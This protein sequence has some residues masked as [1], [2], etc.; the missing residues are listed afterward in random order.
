LLSFEEIAWLNGYHA[1]VREKIGKQID[2]QDG[3]WLEQ[4]TAPIVS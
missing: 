1:Q 2:P 4:A 3:I